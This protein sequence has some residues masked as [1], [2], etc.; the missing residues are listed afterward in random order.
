MQLSASGQHLCLGHVVII[1]MLL[2]YWWTVGQV[3]SEDY[4]ACPQLA[5]WNALAESINHPAGPLADT[6]NCEKCI[7]QWVG[8]HQRDRDLIPGICQSGRCQNPR[9][10]ECQVPRAKSPSPGCSK[11]SCWVTMACLS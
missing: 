9:E 10:P 1:V 11:L 2:G 8:H 7:T 4:N 6:N 5:N 3:S